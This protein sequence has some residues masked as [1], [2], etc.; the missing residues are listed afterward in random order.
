M[1]FV[2]LNPKPLLVISFVPIY[3]FLWWFNLV[4]NYHQQQA[5]YIG[6][7]ECQTYRPP[8]HLYLYVRLTTSSKKFVFIFWFDPLSKSYHCYYLLAGS[9]FGLVMGALVEDS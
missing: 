4:V 7:T 9:S 1:E 8:L 3:M 5:L 6:W 2:S